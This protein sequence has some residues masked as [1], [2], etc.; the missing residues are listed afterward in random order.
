MDVCNLTAVSMTTHAGTHIDA[1]LHFWEDGQ[2]IDMLRLNTFYG[3]CTVI[4]VQGVLTGADMDRLLPYCKRRVLF[5][6]NGKTFL[7]LSAAQVLADSKVVLVGTDANSMPALA[8]SRCSRTSTSPPS[9][10][11]T[12]T[13][14]RSPSS[15]RDSRRL[16]AARYSLKW[17]RDCDRR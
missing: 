7:S 9:S 15:S 1:P 8:S 5:R 17:K 4:A 14:A 16:P 2:S 13:C 6:G 10:R 11:G 3:K 12:M